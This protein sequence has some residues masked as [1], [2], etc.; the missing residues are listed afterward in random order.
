MVEQWNNAFTQ[1]SYICITI[2]YHY[3]SQKARHHKQHKTK[4]KSPSKHRQEAKQKQ[5]TLIASHGSTAVAVA[6]KYSAVMQSP[7]RSA[8]CVPDIGPLKCRLCCALAT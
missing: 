8:P 2:E 7:N 6:L 1:R 3:I 5:A 4:H